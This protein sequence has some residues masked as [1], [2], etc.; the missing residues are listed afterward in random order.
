MQNRIDI[1]PSKSANFQAMLGVE[2]QLFRSS[3]KK[4][5]RELI[6]IRV[7]QINGCAYCIDRHWKEARA[8]GQPEHRLYGLAAWRESPHY[9]GRERAGLLLA[10]ELTRLADRPLP[11]HVREQV[12]GQFNDSEL[13]DLVWVIGSINAWNRVNVG[14]GVQAPNLEQPG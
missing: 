1:D 11:E 3:I 2:K 14:L 7:S 13:D 5:L 8:A 4:A 6:K 10:E 12:R 9:N